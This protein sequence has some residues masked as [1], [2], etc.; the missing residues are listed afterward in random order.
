MVELLEYRDSI[1]TVAFS[2]DSRWLVATGTDS[3]VYIWDVRAGRLSGVYSGHRVDVFA[4]AFSPNGQVATTDTSCEVRVW[5]PITRNT[6]WSESLSPAA[7]AYWLAYSPDGRRIYVVSRTK[8]ITVLDAATGKQLGRVDG[9][10]GDIMDGLAVSPD[11]QLL[12]VGHKVKL[13]VWKADG[14]RP[15]WQV[16]G[17]PDRC[18][19]FSPD[20]AWIATGDQ[21]GAVSLWNVA[22]EGRVCRRLLGHSGSV[23]GVSFHPDGSRLVSCDADGLVKL[24]DW[25]AGVELLSL[26]IP[27]GVGAWHVAFS[28]DGKM[29]AV[30][31]GEGVITLR[32][33]E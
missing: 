11:G 15:L 23:K 9:I 22:S 32:K 1:R 12:A 2:P 28:P 29:I 27:S 13:S 3:G 10:E 33:I 19:A 7:D 17:N 24:W 31:D 8:T 16:D 5:D 21:D 6:V 25:Q 4:V 30:G 14:L 26:P 18:V 20:G